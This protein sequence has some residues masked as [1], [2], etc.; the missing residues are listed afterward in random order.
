MKNVELISFANDR[1]LAQSA[2]KAWLDQID[3]ANR[4]AKVYSVALS[5]G[6]IARTFYSST[7][8]QAKARNISF[9]RVHFFWADERC[10]PTD[11]PES[12]YRLAR[13][14]LFVPL[15]I[16]ENHVHRLRGEDPPADAAR[17]AEADLRRIAS[18]NRSG[19]PVL[20]LIV[21]GLGEDG[22]VASLFPGEREEIAASDAVYRAITNS[23]KPPPNRLTLGYPAISAAKSVWV[24]V[25]GA[26]K[27]KSLQNSLSPA[28]STSLARVLRQR[29]LTEIY[30]DVPVS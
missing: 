27:E 17:T 26:G 5:G 25:S 22:H 1:E 20:D 8:E 30:T 15:N 11:D 24:L 7:V 10:V 3:A 28:G 12:N 21:L 6:R 9:E 16:S 18:A 13:E 23:P 29:Q 2:A 4:D 19:Q 14:G